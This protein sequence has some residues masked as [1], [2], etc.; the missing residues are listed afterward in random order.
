MPRS[1]D[2]PVRTFL[3][4]LA[5]T[6]A[7][8]FDAALVAA[9]PDPAAS[10]AAAPTATPAASLDS[11]QPSPGHSSHGESFNTGPRQRAYLMQG[12]GEIHFEITTKDPVAAQF[13]R[14]GVGQLHGFWYYEAER[15]FRE[16]HAR[17]ETCAMAFW[18][19]AMANV[20]NAKRAKAFIAEAVKL[21]AAAS[22]REQMW[23]DGLTEYYRDEKQSEKDRRRKFIRS[24]E[25]IVQEYPED[26]EA[27]AFLAWAIWASNSQLP[28]SS[29][30]AVDTVLSEVFRAQSNHPA[31]H[32]RIHL[33]DDEKPARALTSAANCG[34]AAPGIAHMWHMPGHT[35]SNTKRFYDAIWQQEA[36]IRVDHAYMMRDRIL[37]SQIHNYAHNSEWC[38]R[39]LST[40]GKVRLGVTIAKNLIEEP[41]HPTSNRFEL[42]KSAA[43]Y[44]RTRLLGLLARYELWPE[45]IAFAEQG[46]LDVTTGDEE[47]ERLRVL[48]AA[49]FN[50]GRTSEGDTQIAA[51]E[52]FGKKLEAERDQAARDAEK[53]AREKQIAD[54]QA[55]AE[56]A[57][58]GKPATGDAGSKEGSQA[59]PGEAKSQTETKPE[60]ESKPGVDS[61]PAADSKPK[62]EPPAAQ[63]STAGPVQSTA[64]AASSESPVPAEVKL[65]EAAIRK[66]GDEAKKKFANRIRSVERALAELRGWKLL[67]AG[68]AKAALAEF[69]K[70]ELHD[71]LLA[72]ICLAAGDVDRAIKLATETVKKSEYQVQPQAILV[73]ILYRGG[74]AQE[75]AEEFRKLQAVAPEIDLD[76]PVV[77][78]IFPLARELGLSEDWRLPR[79]PAADAG[80]R[81]ELGTLGPLEWK[82]QSAPNWEL[83]DA[84]GKPVRL[85]DYRG[86][87]VVMLFF[88]GGGC[89]HCVEQLGKFAQSQPLFEKQG[90][91]IIGVSLDSVSDLNSALQ[92]TEPDE[93][94]LL[95][96]SD[97]KQDIF[98]SYRVYDEFENLPLHGT[99]LI[100]GQGRVRWQDIS[101]EPFLDAKFLAQEAERLLK[102]PA[103]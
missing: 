43:N 96:V 88:L 77:Q 55:A 8:R 81:P 100:D 46:Y 61:K 80:V 83:L 74:K 32:Y 37:P 86:K 27:K 65:D 57:K 54:Q 89:L 67:Q 98:K 23:I 94:P 35:F 73:D 51:L 64:V 39:N 50:V 19:L 45:T 5:L 30:Q 92:G 78:R 82:P 87:P 56:K 70:G 72:E 34:Q 60:A 47:R 52:T 16:A 13:F 90:I 33:W 18:G 79:T 25:A 58:K 101:F 14:Q 84:S 17:D 21:K 75:A 76:L 15:S 85:A 20:N 53:A 2:I 28:I 49:Y 66:A 91:E 7:G 103:E 36:A 71:T 12:V 24:L 9:E 99:F 6:F 40:L 31:H 4:T 48:G 97:A 10:T 93:F 69:E 3:F 29:H 11:T 102:L 68:D 59:K 38:V 41:R 63:P 62:C 42:G 1:I 26:T 22:P 95:L 44:G